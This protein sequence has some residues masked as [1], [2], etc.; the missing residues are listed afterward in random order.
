MRSH[1]NHITTATQ[2]VWSG[3]MLYFIFSLLIN[4]AN[5]NDTFYV[6]AISAFFGFVELFYFIFSI[7][8]AAVGNN[9]FKDS[10]FN[11]ERRKKLTICGLSTSIHA[12]PSQKNLKYL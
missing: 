8:T 5:P 6:H 10:S 1:E 4:A 11:G 12:M 7:S 3:N 2:L 9:F